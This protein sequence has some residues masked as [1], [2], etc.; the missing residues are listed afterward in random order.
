MEF[1]RYLGLM[2][3]MYFQGAYSDFDPRLLNRLGGS[4]AICAR[5][6]QHIRIDPASVLGMQRTMDDR[7]TAAHMGWRRHSAEIR[8]LLSAGGTPS[9]AI[10]SYCQR[11]GTRPHPPEQLQIAVMETENLNQ[12]RI[13]NWQRPTLELRTRMA[14]SGQV[15]GD[16]F[17]A[18]TTLGT[19]MMTADDWQHATPDEWN[20]ALSAGELAV[21]VGALAGAHSDARQQRQDAN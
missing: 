19:L 4:L 10:Y 7:Y 3:R 2:G 20:R 6:V 5:D 14:R 1:R 11:F 13:I 9:D 15:M 17:G 16:T 18:I 12:G 8:S 21:V